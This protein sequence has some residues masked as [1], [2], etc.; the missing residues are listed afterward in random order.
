MLFS[1]LL[2]IVRKFSHKP[3]DTTCS[4]VSAGR[5]ETLDMQVSFMDRRIPINTAD[6]KFRRLCPIV[7]LLQNKVFA[8]GC[9][10]DV[11]TVGYQQIEDKDI[12]V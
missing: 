5:I 3:F 8:A 11:T 12:C 4:N 9:P 2:F 10:A 6:V 1:I 7:G